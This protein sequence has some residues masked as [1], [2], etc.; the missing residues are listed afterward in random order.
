MRWRWWFY[1][2]S[3]ALRGKKCDMVGTSTITQGE[4]RIKRQSISLTMRLVSHVGEGHS[5]VILSQ[6]TLLSVGAYVG[7]GTF[8]KCMT[9]SC[10]QLS[11]VQYLTLYGNIFCT[12]VEC[13]IR[14][15]HSVPEGVC[16][17]GPF[18]PTLP[19]S[20]ICINKPIQGRGVLNNVLF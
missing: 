7:S 11:D 14:D 3:R 4:E 19:Y 13:L 6:Q 16:W 9:R 12:L 10:S 8:R 5:C 20:I 2:F 17:C 15:L 18:V 1:C